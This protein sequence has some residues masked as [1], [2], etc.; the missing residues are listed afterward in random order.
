MACTEILTPSLGWTKSSSE[1]NDFRA[2]IQETKSMLSDKQK[3]DATIKDDR[4]GNQANQ[5]VL[6]L[7]GGNSKMSEDVF[8]LSGDIIETLG[9]KYANSEEE[10]IELVKKL[11]KDPRSLEQMLTTNQKNAIKNLSK[12]IES[13]SVKNN[14][15]QP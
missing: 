4:M 2:A 3:R 5:E 9:T 7:T 14:N 15:R 11:Q 1:D 6:N 10:L 12:E 8:K 13:N